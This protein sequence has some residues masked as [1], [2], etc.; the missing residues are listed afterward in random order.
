VNVVCCVIKR[1]G[2]YLLEYGV[3]AQKY[4]FPGGKVEK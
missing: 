2:K 1:D 3:K 4:V